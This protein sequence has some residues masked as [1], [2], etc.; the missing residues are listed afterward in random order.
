MQL[1]KRH[2]CHRLC[3]SPQ[4]PGNRQKRRNR[5]ARQAVASMQKRKM[6]MRKMGLRRKRKVGMEKRRTR[7]TF[8]LKAPQIR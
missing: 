1:K 3:I 4:D 2:R 7:R 5:L 6:G 8:L